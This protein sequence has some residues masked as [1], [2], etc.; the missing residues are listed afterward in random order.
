MVAAKGCIGCRD[1]YSLQTWAKAALFLGCFKKKKKCYQHGLV[2]MTSMA[3]FYMTCC[4]TGLKA[5]KGCKVLQY[6]CRQVSDMN[7]SHPSIIITNK[8]NIPPSFLKL[9]PFFFLLFIIS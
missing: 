3:V 4:V 6:L 1:V 7:H 9:A 8:I 5:C 2:L